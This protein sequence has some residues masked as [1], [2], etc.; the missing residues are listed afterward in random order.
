MRYKAAAPNAWRSEGMMKFVAIGLTAALSLVPP[1]AALAQQVPPGPPRIAPAP[2]AA[3]PPAAA[4]AAP[5]PAPAAAPAAPRAVQ[6]HDWF[7]GI[8][9]AN[10]GVVTREQFVAHR[11]KLFD[12]LDANKDGTLSKDE[13]LKLAEPPFTPDAPNLPPLAQ[14]QAVFEKQFETIDTDADGKVT[15]GEVQAFI[16]LGF[17]E[18]DIDMDGRATREEVLLVVRQAQQRQDEIDRAIAE[19]NR[20]NPD[21]NGDGMIDSEEFAAFETGRMLELDTNKDG[22]INLQEWLVLAGQA[23]QNPPGQ[24]TYQ[25]RRDVLTKRFQEIDGNKDGQLNQAEIRTMALA[26]FKRI[27]LDGNGKIT[28]QE[29]QTANTPQPPAAAPKA[30]PKPAPAPVAQPRPAPR[31]APAPGPGGL[32]PGVPLGR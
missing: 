8:D 7:K 14:R 13:F 3:K 24:P 23:N 19:R 25:Q 20:N 1:L 29:W 28:P 4:P 18:F 9:T 26:L 5:A 15:R 22:K 6:L 10:S 32:Q 17:R 27:D 30:A 12:Q 2:P 16:A 11:M 31:P 21:R